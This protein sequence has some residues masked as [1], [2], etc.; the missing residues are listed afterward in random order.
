M[1]NIIKRMNQDKDAA[2]LAGPVADAC[3]AVAATHESR[4]AAAMDHVP[5]PVIALLILVSSISAFLLGRSQALAGRIR[6]TTITLILLVSAILY[7]TMDLETPLNGLIQTNQTP[8]LRL[9]QSVGINLT[10]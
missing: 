3:F 8:M 5:P 10:Q 9:A 1:L 4:L 6:R 2:S 7:V